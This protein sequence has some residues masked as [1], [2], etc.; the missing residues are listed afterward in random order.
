VA[1]STTI[2]YRAFLSYSH[3]DAEWAKWLHSALEGYRIDKDLIGRE[4]PLGPVPKTLR[5]IFRDREDFSGGHT[6]TDATIAALD[7]SSALILLCSMATATRPAVNEE[8]R[9]FRARHPQR[10]VIPVIVE[11]TAPENFPAALRFELTSDGAISDRPTTILGPDLRRSVQAQVGLAVSHGMIGDLNVSQGRLEAALASY[12]N[13]HVM[14]E[15]VVNSDPGNVSWQMDLLWSHSRLAVF[16]DRQTERLRYV[17]A[18]LKT[19]KENGRLTSQQELWIPVAER[20]LSAVHPANNDWQWDLLNLYWQTASLTDN[21][22]RQATLVVM[23][24]RKLRDDR[25]LTSAQAE[26]LS[27]AEAELVK[28]RHH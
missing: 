21:P 2:K 13:S 26:W 10:I 28:L 27:V 4:T 15:R 20:A 9:L 12:R 3:V 18:S 25:K 5:P 14:W 6:L 17:V 1:E 23:M 7:A 8:V 11:G 19:A 24:L 16:G 22:V